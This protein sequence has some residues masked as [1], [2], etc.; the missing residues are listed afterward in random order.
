[1]FLEECVNSEETIE[2]NK[3]LREM[4]EVWIN[5]IKDM[6]MMKEDNK[7][8][9]YPQMLTCTDQYL[10]HRVWMIGKEAHHGNE[11]WDIFDYKEKY[12]KDEAVWYKYENEI[13]QNKA[14]KT[15]YL[16]ARKIIAGCDPYDF[17]PQCMAALVN[18]LNKVS[19]GG[20]ETHDYDSFKKI[21]EPFM[22]DG[23]ILN[24]F[25]HELLILKP[26]KIVCCC[27]K[28]YNKHLERAFGYKVLNKIV[29]NEAY[30]QYGVTFDKIQCFEV[31]FDDDEIVEGLGS[32]K[33]MLAI[34]PSAH[35][36]KD[37]REGYNSKISE[38]VSK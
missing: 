31:T 21:Y 14:N 34:H 23:K 5:N 1:M 12:I 16:K 3:K 30:N 13:I 22:Y 33:F 25:Q 28:G 24:V 26:K 20:K 6:P 29:N 7:Q 15:Q 2:I 4:Y 27:G 9:T 36:R 19:K 17:S 32:I 35:L 37:V 10:K 11:V 38:F 18:N 8:I